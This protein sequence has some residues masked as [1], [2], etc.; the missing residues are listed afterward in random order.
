MYLSSNPNAIHLL[1]AN[2]NKINWMGLSMNPNAIHLLEEN[3]DKIIWLYLS[4][5]PNAIHLLEANQN[6]IIWTSIALNPSIF[7]WDY[8]F[9]R[10][11]MDVHREEL[12]KTVFHPKRLK[13]SLEFGYNLFDEM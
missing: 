6:K 9:Y 1:E 11:R 13:R 7:Q 12:M 2:Q 3:Q 8:T 4:C 10:E 5:N